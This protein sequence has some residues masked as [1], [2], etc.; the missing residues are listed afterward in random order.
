MVDCYIAIISELSTLPSDTPPS[1]SHIMLVYNNMY[2]I[3]HVCYSNIDCIALQVNN[4][5]GFIGG[6][7]GEG[8]E[9]SPPKK[10]E[11]ERGGE[12]ERERERRREGG[13]E[14]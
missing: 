12:R 5:Q 8:G 13:R 4:N 14:G 9:A 10:K 6:G 1:P 3:Q 11:G 2:D 7:G